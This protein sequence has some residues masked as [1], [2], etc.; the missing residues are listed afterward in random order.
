M[1]KKF[2]LTKS[3][4]RRRLNEVKIPEKEN[5]VSKKRDVENVLETAVPQTPGQRNYLR[6]LIEKI[7]LVFSE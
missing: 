2:N 4:W 7:A 6:T 3:P 5:T 1:K